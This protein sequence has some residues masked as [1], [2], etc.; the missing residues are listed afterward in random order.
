MLYTFR[1]R[2]NFPPWAQQAQILWR[3]TVPI[4]RSFAPNVRT[5]T[6]YYKWHAVDHLN[7]TQ[8]LERP[9]EPPPRPIRSPP[10]CKKSLRPP[11]PRLKDTCLRADDGPLVRIATYLVG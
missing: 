5:P 11:A 8:E 7:D 1:G 9:R 3:R 10:G 4:L 6:R 2:S